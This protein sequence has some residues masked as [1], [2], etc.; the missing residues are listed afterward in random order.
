MHVCGL[1][2]SAVYVAWEG[3]NAHLYYITAL[4]FVSIRQN[5]LRQN[6]KNILNP[7]RIYVIITMN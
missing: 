5:G 2:E 1:P 3:I 7:D 6:V 4:L